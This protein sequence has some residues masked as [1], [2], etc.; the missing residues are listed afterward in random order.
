[1]SVEKLARMIENLSLFSILFAHMK[2]AYFEW[3]PFH[4]KNTYLRAQINMPFSK[5][6]FV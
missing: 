4:F 6:N 2:H 5:Q 3:V 1:M